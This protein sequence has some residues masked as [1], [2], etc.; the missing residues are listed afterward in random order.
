MPVGRTIVS[1]PKA[2]MLAPTPSI[3]N[4]TSFG[5]LPAVVGNLTTQP[6]INFAA[7]ASEERL[8]GQGPFIQHNLRSTKLNNAAGPGAASLGST[9]AIAAPAFSVP[10]NLHQPD[11]TATLRNIDN[12]IGAAV[13]EVNGVIF[14]AHVTTV[15]SR[16]AIRWYRLDAV[17][18]T[19]LETG[20]LADA[21]ADYS[22]P[23][24]AANENGVIV[25]GF[26]KSS[27]TEFVSSYAVVGETL[28]GATTFEAPM[29]LKAGVANYHY[30]PVNG[31]SRWG[32]FSSTN[33]DPTDPNVFWTNQEFVSAQDVW[34]TQITQIR[35]VPEPSALL[36]LTASAGLIVIVRGRARR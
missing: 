4:R 14:A 3:A 2:D 17:T 29:L 33:V 13:Y 35:I 15:N 28:G 24:I 12:R 11:G 20:L 31:L 16:S 7:A 27:A 10:V 34:S 5:V 18:D 23:S 19:L 6:V 30:F 1:I 26:N 21:S 25:I 36:M 32:D 8:L 22:F 9:T